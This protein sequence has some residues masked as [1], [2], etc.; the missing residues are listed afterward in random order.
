MKKAIKKSAV[1]GIILMISINSLACS[2]VNTSAAVTIESPPMTAAMESSTAQASESNESS[3]SNV[4]TAGNEISYDSAKTMSENL[5]LLNQMLEADYQQQMAVAAVKEYESSERSDWVLIM[6]GDRPGIDT[7]S[8]KFDYEP[9]SAEGRYM[10]A[11]LTTFIF[12]YGE[13]MGS[14]LWR[15]TGD[16][17][18]GGADESEYGFK[19]NGGQVVYKDSR[20]ASFGYPE[21]DENFLTIYLWMTPEEIGEY[22]DVID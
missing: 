8:W 16:L 9:D 3:E 20:A 6:D 18:D 11:V 15:M 21:Q 2:T 7:A 12:F 22:Q 17:L 19:H 14:S 10:D 13:E 1:T 4:N 5:L